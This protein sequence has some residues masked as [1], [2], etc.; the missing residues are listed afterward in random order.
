MSEQDVA[1]LRAALSSGDHARLCALLAQVSAEVVAAAI[2][3]LDQDAAWAAVGPLLDALIY[4]GDDEEAEADDREVRLNA[5]LALGH[6]GDR[7][8]FEPL[9]HALAT[10]DLTVRWYVIDA[11][12]MLADPRAVGPLIAAL[13]H[14]DIDMR[15]AAWRA[16]AAIG[17]PA[18]EPLLAAL[19]SGDAYSWAT[20]ALGAIGDPRAISPLIAV[21]T[22]RSRADTTRYWAAAALGQLGA[23]AAFG[24]LV[25]LLEDDTEPAR[26]RRG[27]A[28][29]LGLLKDARAVDPLLALLDTELQRPVVTALGRIG[30]RRVVERLIT[31]LQSDTA[32]HDTIAQALAVLG[33]ARALPALRRLQPTFSMDSPDRWTRVA[34]DRS[35]EHLEQQVERR[36]A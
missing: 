26:V 33:D 4:H 36:D 29:G 9:L 19:A 11:L 25:R 6:L 24:L 27:A 17:A 18:V 23:A 7:Q 14:P 15:K 31:L 21:L 12:G 34:I 8:S 2:V 13:A 10:D 16:L 1:A 35:I 32:A 28:E 5:A 3:T 30:D 20:R 22:D